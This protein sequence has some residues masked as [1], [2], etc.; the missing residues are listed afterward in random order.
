M[1]SF[2]CGEFDLLYSP[3]STYFLIT[4]LLENF[5]IINDFFFYFSIV[6]NLMTRLLGPLNILV[7]PQCL[8]AMGPVQMVKLPVPVNSLRATTL[9]HPPVYLHYQASYNFKFILIM[10]S[11]ISLKFCHHNFKKI[12]FF[13]TELIFQ[14]ETWMR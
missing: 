7:K 12:F 2:F 6:F 13:L 11:N 8:R 4:Q 1:V 10:L 3:C 9:G 5:C 14:D